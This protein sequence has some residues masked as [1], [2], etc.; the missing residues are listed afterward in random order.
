MYKTANH[1]KWN[2]TRTT[3]LNGSRSF[4]ASLNSTA[5]DDYDNDDD[6]CNMKRSGK[7][8]SPYPYGSFRHHSK[9]FRA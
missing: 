5:Y 1:E 2:V 9:P 6:N 7:A 8:W 3:Y 4:R